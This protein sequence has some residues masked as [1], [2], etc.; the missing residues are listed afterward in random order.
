MLTLSPE[1]QFMHVNECTHAVRLVLMPR[2]YDVNKH[3]LNLSHH[4][5]LSVYAEKL[6]SNNSVD[7]SDEQKEEGVFFYDV[8]GL[9]KYLPRKFY[10][11]LKCIS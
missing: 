11:S 2:L 7:I 5:C 1:R 4:H 10:S 6:V 9:N 8:F 3:Q